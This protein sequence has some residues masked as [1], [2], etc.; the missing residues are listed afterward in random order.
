[1]IWL[2]R[3]K[4]EKNGRWWDT[5]QF[6]TVDVQISPPFD[7][8]WSKRE[9][10]EEREWWCE[11]L[12]AARREEGSKLRTKEELLGLCLTGMR[13][14]GKWRED[15]GKHQEK[16]RNTQMMKRENSLRHYSKSSRFS[17]PIFLIIMKKSRSWS[18]PERKSKRD[19]GGVRR[20]RGEENKNPICDMDSKKTTFCSTLMS[21][22]GIFANSDGTSGWSSL[23]DSPEDT[24]LSLICFLSR[25]S[26]YSWLSSH[27][28]EST[29]LFSKLSSPP[30]SLKTTFTHFV[31]SGYIDQDVSG[32]VYQHLWPF[33]S[34]YKTSKHL[35]QSV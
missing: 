11:G 1:M 31:V 4:Q 22:Y 33:E 15:E 26:F 9:E 5:G 2:N 23:D 35:Q 12:S 25:H 6:C 18:S 14:G 16:E 20:R 34:K 10:K 24:L 13:R 30:F 29:P 19:G 28:L 17:P 7:T 3:Q 21:T 27:R 32:I 8:W